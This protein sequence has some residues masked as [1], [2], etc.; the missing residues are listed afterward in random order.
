MVM[1]IVIMLF[2]II[3]FSYLGVREFPSI[4]PPVITVRTGY[5]GAN[6]DIIESQITE[7]L[8]KVIN[9]ISGV[10]SISSAS[11]LGSSVITV[12]FNLGV[13]LEEAANDVRDKV[14]QAIR[15]LPQD[16]DQAPVVSKADANSEAI[17]S[18]TVQSSTRTHLEV[19]DYAE[20]VLLERLQTIPGVSSLQMWGQKRYAMRIWLEPEKL[21][22]FGLTA[23]DVKV[24]LDRENIE[25]P[26]GKIEG[27]NTELTIKTSGRLTNEDEFNDLIIT[28]ING[29]AV[30]LNDVGKAVLGTENEQS[31]LKSGK[32]PMVALALVPL[33]GANHIDIAKEFY[34]RYE[35]IKKEVPEDFKIDIVLD[36]TK[37]VS[38]S[39]TEV[40]ETLLI[41]FFL[42][43]LIIFLFFR[44]WIIAV[45]PLIDI[46]V[47]LLGAFFIMYL[48]GFSI[49][50]LTLLGIV[51]ATGLV[52]DDGIVVTEN[53]FKK[54][55]K[56]LGRKQAA[57]E[58]TNEIFFA[59]IATSLSLAIVFLP[60]IF[61]QGFVGRL[62]REFGVV[63]AGAVLI[64]SFVS[65][66]LTPVLSVYLQRRSKE[67]TKFYTITEPFFVWLNK[68]YSQSLNAFMRRR[69]LAWLL[70]LMSG[71]AIFYYGSTLP[72][73]LSP[74]DDRSMLR[75]SATA[76]E[77]SSYEYMDAYMDK[78]G[79]ITED[80]VPEMRINLLVT[81]PQF[82]GSGAVN[83][84]F[85]RIGLV[86]PTQRTRTQNEIAQKLQK[87][88][89]LL[90]EARSFVLQE[91]TI[92]GS[93][94]PRVGLPVQFILQNQSFEKLQ[95]AVPKFMA[96]AA[97]S[98]VFQGVDVNLK[99][100]RPELVVSINRQK[101]Q[102]LGVSV[103]AIAQTLQFVYGGIRYGYFTRNGKQ[104]QIIGQ[105]NRASRDEPADLQSLY[106]K[107]NK[108]KLIQLDNVVDI[109][110]QSNPPQLY[111]YNRFK[112]ATVSAGLAPGKTLGDGIDEMRRIASNVLD[113][114]FATELSG[115]SRDFAESSSNTM[116]AFLLALLLVFLILAAQFESFR[117][118]II[119]MI[120]VPLAL[121][122]ALFSLWYFNQT[123]NIFSQIGIIVLLGLVTKN[124][125]LIVEFA[126]QL[127]EK[128]LNNNEAVK[129]AAVARLRPILM[130]SLAT[131]L[132]A[133]PIALALGSG[134]TSRIPMGIVI[135]GGL[136]FSGFLTL[137]VVPA[138]YS[139]V[140]KT[141]S[142]IK[143]SND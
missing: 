4:D 93:G 115:P 30:R 10:R 61:L 40:K 64:S 68:N 125:I 25:L 103:Q 84:G 120:T 20:N 143:G 98:P 81:S 66:T 11:N 80:S 117:D 54:I 34:K 51:L 119:I 9:G 43:V 126:N 7:P 59:V 95:Q 63:L 33:P 55:E 134:S 109:E 114:T 69:W 12:E 3:S 74:L 2:G 45:R 137:Y 128:G 27:N 56:G 87:D 118:P 29:K 78:L 37:F 112:S 77:G 19:S 121:A 42:V 18:M 28:N 88:V 15:Q 72:S 136:I 48:A 52:V 8:E 94:G 100:N 60:I 49:N 141:T 75:I 22:A 129:Q 39:I 107:N 133:L 13:D 85:A 76:P 36:N 17:I 102:N 139:Y 50:I 79:Q 41:A 21:A 91:Q 138:I 96:E 73:E 14:S 6:P 99:F 83:T 104:Y 135:V 65:L 5:A 23:L 108:G 105:A 92:S 67:P 62:F 70:V 82:T 38:K 35:Q 124:G 24:A 130:T 97:K 47:S 113:E 53:I 142:N 58:G 46:P 32:L 16:I 89:M 132:G 31:V 131:I 111:H 123:I 110:E 90:I 86:E 71:G 140:S 44:D 26:G 1:S 116:F 127:K 57:I 101:A 122:G 106:V